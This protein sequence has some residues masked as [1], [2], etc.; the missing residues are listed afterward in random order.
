MSAVGGKAD[1]AVCGMSHKLCHLFLNKH[2]NTISKPGADLPPF[3]P[4]KP[5][6]YGYE[7]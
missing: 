3:C 7:C 1:M 5:V 2:E 6:E 4:D